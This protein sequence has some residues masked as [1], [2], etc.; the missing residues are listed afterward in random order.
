[1]ENEQI[2]KV[3]LDYS[4]YPGEDK[5]CDGAVE[6]EI[7]SVV[8]KNAEV[9]YPGIIAEKA[10]WPF[11]YHLSPIRENIVEW[12]PITK[13]DKVLEVGSGCGAITG[14]LSR[15]AYRVDCVDLSRQRS[16]INAYRHEFC[17]NMMIH[18]GN[19]K[20]IEPTLPK[21]YDLICLIGVF[22][23]GEAYIGGDDPF[24]T[25]LKTLKSH[26]REGGRIAIAIE[27]KF[28]LKYFAGC[29][30]D[31]SGKLFEGIMDYPGSTP[32]KTFSERGLLEIA[33]KSGFSKEECHMYYPYPDY[34]FMHTL[35][36]KDR[37]PEEG[38]LKDNIRNFD[39]NRLLLFDEK[40]AFEN[41]LREEQ[42]PMFSN[43]YMLI[44]GKKPEIVYARFSNDRELA[45]CIVTEKVVFDK[46][47]GDGTKEG[48]Y[49]S[50]RALTE[51][52][53]P[54][55]KQMK[56]NYEL[57]KKRYEG[58]SL[59]I[60]PCELSEDGKEIFFPIASGKRLEELLDERVFCG[61]YEGFRKLFIEY[62]SRIGYGENE[63]VA[64]MDLIFSNVII[65]GDRWVAID[66]EWVLKEKKFTKEIAFRALYCYILEDERRNC[67][68]AGELF[69]AIGITPQELAEYRVAEENFQKTVTGGHKSL[70]QM[71]ELIGNEIVSAQAFEKSG[72]SAIMGRLQVYT[73]EG[74]GFSEKNSFFPERS[75]EGYEIKIKGELRQLRLDPCNY[76]C[77]VKIKELSLD[78][79][80]IDVASREFSSNGY[81]VNGKV[82][83]FGS[84]DPNFTL[85]FR[86]VE[87]KEES[88]IRASFDITPLPE[89][90]AEDLPQIEGSQGLIGKLKRVVKKEKNKE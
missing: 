45:K 37:L 89:N 61:D 47:T 17:D 75:G 77:I 23:Y 5:Y 48:E 43:S 83:A 22:E 50:M 44:L 9:E 53:I 55:I 20:D 46:T 21:N 14:A 60:C 84:D 90:I 52:A 51:E 25:F 76:P 69:T 33:E 54:H 72:K 6:K 26:L 2:G 8:K 74:E 39:R 86:G 87:L 40:L 64:D 73:D 7:L 71:R 56:E 81:K 66:Y 27:N 58:S 80:E 29:R 24:V 59:T 70:A 79:D 78:G 41:I 63:S 28:G 30:E 31:H 19:F 68:D 36:S 62:F 49:I 88:T 1:M 16:L 32:A 57:L 34:K 42:F 4:N 10:S 82:F 15:K 65:D 12:L 67:F 38:E 35:F 18:V 85:N 11:L 3:K 13:D